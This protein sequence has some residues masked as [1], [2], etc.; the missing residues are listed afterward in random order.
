MGDVH[1]DGGQGTVGDGAADGTSESEARVESKTSGRVRCGH[2]SE[3][4]LGGVDLAGAGGSGGR[5]GGHGDGDGTDDREVSGEV[6][7]WWC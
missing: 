3:L 7:C 6:W 1:I 5:S 4:G 2:G